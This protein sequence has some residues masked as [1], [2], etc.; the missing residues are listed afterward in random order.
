[1]TTT[2]MM[3]NK[4]AIGSLACLLGGFLSCWFDDNRLEDK[5]KAVCGGRRR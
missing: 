5:S 1:M 4:G 2:T 3:M